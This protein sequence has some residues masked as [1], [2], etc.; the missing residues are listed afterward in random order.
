M[1]IKVAIG[2]YQVSN[3]LFTNQS[4]LRNCHQ[5]KNCEQFRTKYCVNIA[6]ILTLATTHVFDKNVTKMLQ[7]EGIL[8]VLK[9]YIVWSENELK[10]CDGMSW[11]LEA[12]RPGPPQ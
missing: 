12:G 3:T 6:A 11:A 4:A 7:Q 1:G 9:K 5:M 8:G 2:V 10:F